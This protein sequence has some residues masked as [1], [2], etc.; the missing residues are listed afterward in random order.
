MSLHAPFPPITQPEALFDDPSG[1]LHGTGLRAGLP[2]GPL[3][4][5][6]ERVARFY[7]GEG[8]GGGRLVGAIP[9]DRHAE[10][11]L[12]QPAQWQDLTDAAVGVNAAGP[13]TIGACRMAPNPVP[14]GFCSAVDAGLT[15]IAAGTLDKIVLSR[16]LDLMA[17]EQID[18]TA[19]LLALRRD[20]MAMVF[21]VSL[22]D[23]V[24]GQPRRLVGAT[25][26]LLVERRGRQ[27]RSHPLAGSAPRQADP[28]A[29]RAVSARL[30]Q[31]AKDAYEHK[32]AA[33]AVL[34]SL[35]PFCARLA[36]P[37][38]MAL[39]GT[40]TMW[41]LGTRIEGDL[42]DPDTPVA[43]LLAVL[44]P[45]PAVCGQPRAAAAQAIAEIEGYDRDFYA[46]AVG[47]TDAAGDG[48]WHVALRCAEIDGNA[49][50]LYAGVGVVDGSRAEDELAETSAKFRTVLNAFGLNEAGQPLAPA[51][52]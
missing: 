32:I 41:H 50:R 3:A 47:W 25:P 6:A 15:R 18:P 5:L 43:E 21:S 10:D 33:E 48:T 39:H 24:A 52:S 17:A 27:V 49:A 19:L 44:H 7:A 16:R 34:D 29:D 14:S 38:G 51:A 13:L 45:T 9:F 20:P 46:G 11:S 23:R 4:T 26:E 42:R 12:F 30:M 31:S 40:A 22:P 2:R 35:A 1:H 36:A 8:A 37:E 28:L